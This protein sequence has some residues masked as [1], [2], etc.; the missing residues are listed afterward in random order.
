M[1]RGLA[2]RRGLFG[3]SVV[4]DVVQRHALLLVKVGVGRVGIMPELGGAEGARSAND[5]EDR[6]GLLLQ[7]PPLHKRRLPFGLRRKCATARRASRISDGLGKH[8]CFN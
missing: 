3:V 2:P 8:D 6:P 1:P 7:D 4:F 5:N